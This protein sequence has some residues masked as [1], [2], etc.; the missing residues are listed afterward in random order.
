MTRNIDIYYT[1]FDS[2]NVILVR[3]MASSLYQARLVPQKKGETTQ[4]MQNEQTQKYK[5]VQL[6]LALDRWRLSFANPRGEE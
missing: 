4:K 3:Y 5:K 6:Y 1:S 2:Y